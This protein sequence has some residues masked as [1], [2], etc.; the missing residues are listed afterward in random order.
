MSGAPNCASVAPGSRYRS[1]ER[2]PP[3][4]RCAAPC[5]T[6]LSVIS[7]RST[8]RERVGRLASDTFIGGASDRQ[9]A[10]AG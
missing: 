6:S 5:A 8:T 2:K 3:P 7:L 10:G 1:R 9:Q 4:S